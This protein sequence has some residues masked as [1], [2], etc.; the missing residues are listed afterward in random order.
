[1][2]NTRIYKLEIGQGHNS[3][4]FLCSYKLFPLSLERLAEDFTKLKMPYPYNY[5]KLDTLY[6]KG[7]PPSAFWKN[8]NNFE[9]YKSALR[10]FIDF[11]Q[12][13]ITYCTNDVKKAHSFVK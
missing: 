4:I 12:Y 2:R 7:F 3:I 1:M 6:Y 5:I 10:D 13:G 8:S 11:K 9:D